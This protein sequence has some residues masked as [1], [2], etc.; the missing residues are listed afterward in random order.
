MNLMVVSIFFYQGFLDNDLRYNS[1]NWPSSRAAGALIITS[2]PLLFFG[3]AIKSLMVS[4]P[5]SMATKRSS[6]NATRALEPKE[7]LERLVVFA[8]QVW[9]HAGE[10]E[11]SVERR[12]DCDPQDQTAKV[13]LIHHGD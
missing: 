12:E 7:T 11:Q 6:P 1:F 8:W 4:L 5:P 13:H 10:N 9:R 3:N 2:L